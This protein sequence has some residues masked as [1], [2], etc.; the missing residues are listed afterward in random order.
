[1]LKCARKCARDLEVSGKMPNFAAMENDRFVITGI[2]KLSGLREE[3]SG[4]MPR[5]LAEERLEREK[6]NRR[7]QRYQTHSRLRIE[8]ML[9]VQLTLKFD[10]YDK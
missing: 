6:S 2:N 5:A 1:M 8:R 3:I 7:Y 9:P 4:A 10:D